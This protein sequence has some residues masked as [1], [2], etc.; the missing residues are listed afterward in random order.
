MVSEKG[1]GPPGIVPANSVDANPRSR[2]P[3]SF[4]LPPSPQI[5]PSV[6]DRTAERYLTGPAWIRVAARE[7]IRTSRTGFN[8]PGLARAIVGRV[9][10]PLPTH[11]D[12]WN[13]NQVAHPRTPQ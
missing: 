9:P 4:I 6:A 3:T 7:R 5:R 1:G 11:R 13:G 8:T 10:R 12:K 2:Y